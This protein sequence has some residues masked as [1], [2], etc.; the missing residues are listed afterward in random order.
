MFTKIHARVAKET[1][2]DVLNVLMVAAGEYPTPD[3]LSTS[4][5]AIHIRLTFALYSPKVGEGFF[6]PRNARYLRRH[7]EWP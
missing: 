2:P 7:C 4:Q 5:K 6:S 1:D 3:A